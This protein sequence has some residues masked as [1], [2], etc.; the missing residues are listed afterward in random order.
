MSTVKKANGHH[1]N[2]VIE[3]TTNTNKMRGFHVAWI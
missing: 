2:Q 1:L 3:D